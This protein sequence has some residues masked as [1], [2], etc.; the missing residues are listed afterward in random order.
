ML[1]LRI[2]CIITTIWNK[3]FLRKQNAGKMPAFFNFLFILFGRTI[4][5]LFRYAS[6]LFGK[7]RQFLFQGIRLSAFSQGNLVHSPQN[8]ASCSFA[9]ACILHLPD[10]VHAGTY[11]SA[12]RQPAHKPSFFFQQSA[13]HSPQAGITENQFCLVSFL[14]LYFCI[15]KTSGHYN[16]R[17]QLL[18][19]ENM[20]RTLLQCLPQK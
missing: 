6:I 3:Q 14:F 19:F 12:S 8:N 13:Q 4:C 17:F 1:R 7:I 9:Q 11:P 2:S 18:L 10:S 16:D 15:K 20:H 5:L